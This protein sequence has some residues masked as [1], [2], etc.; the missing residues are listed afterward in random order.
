[1]GY[2]PGYHAIRMF[3]S[4]SLWMAL[5][6]VALGFWEVF[7]PGSRSAE[8]QPA[9]SQSVWLAFLLIGLLARRVSAALEAQSRD[10]DSLK[11]RLD[12]VQL[13]R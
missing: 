1:M 5:L 3:G 10:I 13:G 2:Y 9:P 12:Q 4:V 8:Y 7:A 11:Q 6:V